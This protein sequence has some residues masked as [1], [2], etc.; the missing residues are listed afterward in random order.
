MKLPRGPLHQ[1][2]ALSNW[3]LARPTVGVA[4]DLEPLYL[5]PNLLGQSSDN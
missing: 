4:G 5:K 2:D 3:V 1:D